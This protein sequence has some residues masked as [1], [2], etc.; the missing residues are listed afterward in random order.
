M[1]SRI[2]RILAPVAAVSLL[3][4]SAPAAGAVR[5]LADAAEKPVST[6][7]AAAREAAR[8]CGRLPMALQLV[9]AMVREEKLDWEEYSEGLTLWGMLCAPFLISS[10]VSA[11]YQMVVACFTAPI[12]S[13][14]H[15]EQHSSLVANRSCSGIALN[16][17]DLYAIHR[18]LC[19]SPITTAGPYHR[20]RDSLYPCDFPFR[21]TI[22]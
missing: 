6:E 21:H 14:G 20:A 22:T 10:T 8:L 16:T 13:M 19:S 7:N 9:G 5:I 4:A 1:S 15:A 11:D 3:V 17:L 18:L 12:I 2:V